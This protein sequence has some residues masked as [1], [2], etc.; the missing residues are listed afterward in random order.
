MKKTVYNLIVSI[1]CFF[2][3]MGAIDVSMIMTVFAQETGVSESDYLIEDGILREYS[4]NRMVKKL[5][6]PEGVEE[7]APNVFQDMMPTE[8]VLPSTF[9]RIH[10]GDFACLYSLERINV[11]QDVEI[12]NGSFFGCSRLKNADGLVVI[13]NVIYDGLSA[14]TEDGVLTI[15]EGIVGIS[16]MAFHEA[17]HVKK[18]ILPESVRRIESGAFAMCSYLEEIELNDGLEYVGEDAFSFTALKA[19]TISDAVKLEKGALR[20]AGGS[21][22]KPTTVYGESLSKVEEEATAS[23]CIF[24]PLNAQLQGD[25]NGSNAFE[26]EDALLIL[27]MVVQLEPM[28]GYSAD[29]NGDGEITADD[30]LEVLQIVV[31]LK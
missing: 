27:K 29:T 2:V 17:W 6:I 14:K 10:A 21:K 16:S 12:E 8:I 28:Y 26:A 30:A 1:A 25:V 23:N 22:Y 18:V 13:N 20:N 3:L 15:P 11:A 9:K 24:V 4:G 7:L 19:L 5:V 31:N